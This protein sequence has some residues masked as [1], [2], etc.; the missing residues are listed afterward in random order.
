[1]IESQ[2]MS[3]LRYMQ[4]TGSITALDAMREFGCMRLGARCYDLKKLGY[5]IRSVTETSK[6]RYGRSVSYSRYSLPPKGQT[7]FKL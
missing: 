2:A 3:I 6:N 5:D 7:E 1:M 4:E